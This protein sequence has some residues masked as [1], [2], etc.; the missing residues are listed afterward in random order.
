MEKTLELYSDFCN[1]VAVNNPVK[2]EDDDN[3]R[4]ALDVS[5]WVGRPLIE[6]VN[7]NF[8]SSSA[9]DVWEKRKAMSFP[10]GAPCTNELK[11][12]ARQDYEANHK[13]TWHVLGF[14]VD[15]RHRYDRFVLSERSNVLPVSMDRDWETCQ[16]T[17]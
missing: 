8:P 3:R 9:F 11:K 17:L 12:K 15:E 13:V 14:T 2:E 1:V 4:F 16:V 5:D 10:N 6:W 7:P